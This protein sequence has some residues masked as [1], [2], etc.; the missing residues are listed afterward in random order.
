MAKAPGYRTEISEARRDLTS[1]VQYL[2]GAQT[3]LAEAGALDWQMTTI[4]TH[5]QQVAEIIALVQKLGQQLGEKL[6]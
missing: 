3:H 2:Q 1:A 5:P 6:S 4:A